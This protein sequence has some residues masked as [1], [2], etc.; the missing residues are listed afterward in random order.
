MLVSEE[1]TKKG[2]SREG[3]ETVRVFFGFLD[4]PSRERDDGRTELEEGFYHTSKINGYP[5]CRSHGRNRSAGKI[6]P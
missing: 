1:R 5:C 4:P 3:R 6:P 2:K